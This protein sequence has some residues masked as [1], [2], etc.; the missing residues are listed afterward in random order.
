MAAAH[1]HLVRHLPPK[2]EAYARAYGRGDVPL[3]VDARDVAGRM[4]VL[5]QT[6]PKQA[7]WRV[8]SIPRAQETAERLLFQS[9]LSPVDCVVDA[10]F[11]EQDFGAFADRLLSELRDDPDFRRYKD[12]PIAMAPPGGESFTDCFNRVGLRL[13]ALRQETGATIIVT[14][15][16]VVRA[17][18]G[19]SLGL[20]PYQAL[21]S[22][23]ISPLMHAHIEFTGKAWRFHSLTQ[24]C[25]RRA[26]LG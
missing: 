13:E 21:N 6:L 10:G 20:S 15:G 22:I 11:D 1:F 25:A 4:A 8:S 7:I 12:D 9:D 23:A 16:G 5:G 3:D 26:P 24:G 14:H 2:A 18:L 19:L 17:A